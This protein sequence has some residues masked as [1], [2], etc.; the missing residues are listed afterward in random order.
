M[1]P[2]KLSLLP[3]VLCLLSL[4]AFAQS[5]EQVPPSVTGAD[6]LQGRAADIELLTD[7][8]AIMTS[9][10][11]A[12]NLDYVLVGQLGARIVRPDFRH[13]MGFLPVFFTEG[14]P[15]RSFVGRAVIGH[16]GRNVRPDFTK[17]DCA[18]DHLTDP[19]LARNVFLVL[20][21]GQ[22][23]MNL[24]D[25][26]FGQNRIRMLGAAL[27]PFGV[28]PGTVGVSARHS[29]GMEHRAMPVA[30]CLSPFS[31]PVGHVVGV[32][33]RKGVTRIAARRVITSMASEQVARISAGFEKEG[34]AVRAVLA[35]ANTV[36]AIAV[37]FEARNP[38]PAIIRAK[39]L[40]FGPKSFDLLRCQIGG[41]RIRLVQSVT[42]ISGS[43]LMNAA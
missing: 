27:E 25:I 40:N 29:L 12:A 9:G 41:N 23:P 11:K 13:C 26:G 39:S 37:A 20:P 8:P 1:K 31:I 19:K 24:Q 21:G 38:R 36:S 10:Q 17:L 32:G 34:Q 33:T 30:P 22:K 6:M 5:S 3:I 16:I 15:M 35:L 14:V 28:L 42:S 18:D 4:S 7:H 2:I 43:G